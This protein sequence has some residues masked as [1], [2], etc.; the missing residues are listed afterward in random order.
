MYLSDDDSEKEQTAAR[1]RKWRHGDTP[2][3]LVERY[4]PE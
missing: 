3:E 4:T 1:T 2:D